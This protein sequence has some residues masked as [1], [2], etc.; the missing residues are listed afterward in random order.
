MA[1][2][3]PTNRF[4]RDFSSLE[5]EL[6]KGTSCPVERMIVELDLTPRNVRAKERRAGISFAWYRT[7]YLAMKRHSL[8]PVGRSWT[9]WLERYARA[10][11]K[12]ALALRSA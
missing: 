1:K 3:S 2:Q 9:K 4:L 11:Q 6:A 12:A 5:M 10:R 8:L 7:P